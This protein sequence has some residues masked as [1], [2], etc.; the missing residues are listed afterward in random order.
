MIKTVRIQSIDQ[1]DAARKRELLESTSAQ[2]MSMLFTLI[3]QTAKQPKL[4]RVAQ[5]R[6]LPIRNVP[7]R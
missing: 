5:I 4:K 3:D 1:Q 2:R 6:I 7:V